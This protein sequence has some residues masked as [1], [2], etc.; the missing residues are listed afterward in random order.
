M[1]VDS[2][3]TLSEDRLGYSW[4]FAFA[5]PACLILP[6]SSRS[7][8]DLRYLASR[9]TSVHS[10]NKRWS[11]SQQRRLLHQRLGAGECANPLAMRCLG[12]MPLSQPAHAAVI[13]ISDA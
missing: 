7:C 1:R 5:L 12:E 3:D 4:K 9:L 8:P 10:K 11:C 6:S 2:L 13:Q